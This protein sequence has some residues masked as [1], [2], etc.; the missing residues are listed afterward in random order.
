[1]T[2]C[3]PSKL[4]PNC[5]GLG[6]KGEGKALCLVCKGTGVVPLI[7]PMTCL[8]CGKKVIRGELFPVCMLGCPLTRLYLNDEDV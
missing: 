6:H 8:E 4:C 3:I 2:S 7:Y 5:D 1:M